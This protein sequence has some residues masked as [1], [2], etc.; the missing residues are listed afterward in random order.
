L[1]KNLW[2]QLI[3]ILDCNVPRRKIREKLHSG[4]F[5]AKASIPA[6]FS[7]DQIVILKDIEYYCYEVDFNGFAGLISD[8]N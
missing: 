7:T 3:L 6:H 8:W 1:L 2:N 4:V 5:I